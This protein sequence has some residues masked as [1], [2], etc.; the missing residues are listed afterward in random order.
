MTLRAFAVPLLLAAVPLA[1]HAQAG[2]DP[3]P[4][5]VDS[6]FASLN[7]S[8]GPGCALG[9]LRAGQLVYARGYGMASLEQ[10][11]AI[12]PQSV[13]YIAS[14]SKQFTAA[15]VAL[16][17]EEG[18]ISLDDPIR[19][20]VPELPAWADS[21]TVRHLVHHTSGVRDYL[22]LTIMAG[23]GF[24]DEIPEDRAI[25]LIARQR[26]VNF[27]PGARYSYSNS[28]YFLLSVIVKR[29]TGTSLREY[30]EARIFRPLGM[31][32]THFHDDR[33]M[34]VP[35]RV[36]GY[37]PRPGG[38]W[39]SMRTSF[40]LVGDGGLLTTIED[41]AKWDG[42]F[43]HNVLGGRGDAFINQITTP[44]QLRNSRQLGYAF[45]L[46]RDSYR[47]LPIVTHGGTFPGFT[48]SLSRF[49]EQRF[50]VAVLCNDGTA[51]TDK[52]A[53]KVADLY[54]ATAFPPVTKTPVVA[55]DSARAAGLAGRYELFPGMVVTIS[56][57]GGAVSAS[58]P[59]RPAMPL[60]A[61]SESSFALPLGGMN[62][63]FRR[64]ASGRADTVVV[65]SLNTEDPS[66]R[67]PDPPTLTAAERAQYAG[68]YWSEELHAIY[69]V[70]A[71]SAGL[72]IRP[73]N[74]KLQPLEPLLKDVFVMPGTRVVF[75]RG[76]GNRITGASVSAGRSSGVRF[77]RQP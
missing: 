14:T 73:A 17:A 48:A 10:G 65:R 12:T 50:S 66:P 77:V 1:A 31:S 44:G 52:L 35:D 75:E 71:D 30:A 72:K 2:S 9:V 13:F 26:G 36:E 38:G 47:G 34:V 61:K 3:T 29:V 55:L 8:N 40:A 15:A 25:A 54:L 56:A 5:R 33:T 4:A 39:S 24:G 62:L 23:G 59:G 6:V 68:S 28:G 32:H 46:M 49:P 60:A 53:T 37:E 18:R 63:T 58:I 16:L 76:K 45:G 69:S 43:Y 20:F 42:N 74:Q 21:I 11:V 64:G 67:L 41:L 51:D 70:E 57:R 7:R 22:A 27:S 19:K